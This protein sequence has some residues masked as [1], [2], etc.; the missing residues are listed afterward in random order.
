[1]ALPF[2][3]GSFDVMLSLQ[4]IEHLR[5]QRAFLDECARVL[6]PGGRLAL[7]TPNRLTFPPGNPFHAHEL[8]A[9]DLKTL[10]GAGP[11]RI[12]TLDGLGHGG[13]IAAFEAVHGDLVDAQLATEPDGRP[14]D[15][16]AFV[17]AVTADDF[18]L[19]GDD[20][21]ASLDLRL[22]AVRR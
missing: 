12:E 20:V 7:T 17:A 4:T 11:F 15:L 16:A 2:A 21:D 1:V 19:S 8:D 9:T 5:D 22:V 14:A 3:A 10:V 6:R 18:I 13:R